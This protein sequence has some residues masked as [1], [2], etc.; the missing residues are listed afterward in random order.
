[1]PK[2]FGLIEHIH[3]LL[4]R[5]CP[6]PD[7]SIGVHQERIEREMRAAGVQ[8]YEPPGASM[9][10]PLE[11]LN[12]RDLSVSAQGGASVQTTVDTQIAA[13]LYPFS[14]TIR[15][16]ATVLDGLSG[17]VEIPI[18]RASVPV[19][20]SSTETQS[21]TEGDPQLGSFSLTPH[22]ITA[23]IVVSKQLLRQ[24]PGSESW[25]KRELALA[26][27][28]E[29]DRIALVGSGVSGQPLGVLNTPTVQPILFGGA[30]TWSS[31]VNFETLV[32]KTE[33]AP[34]AVRLDL[35]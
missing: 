28:A 20:W 24:A 1:M 29:V 6:L 32:G 31:V 26:L 10:V 34:G 30:A 5:G 16:G 21:A 14:A 3:S 12:Q 17:N 13:F 9:W 33:C 22:N 25:V 8:S 23:Q 11:V 7:D 2:Q 15:L 27:G 19:A 35:V 4:Q 18:G